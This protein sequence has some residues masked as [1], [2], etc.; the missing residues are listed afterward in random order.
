[1]RAPFTVLAL[2]AALALSSSAFALEISKYPRAYKGGEGLVVKVVSVKGEKKQALVQI[3]GVDTELDEIVLLTEEVNAGKGTALKTR[4]HGED[5]WVMR[6]DET[7]YG[8]KSMDVYLPETPTK[9]TNVYYDEAASKKVKGDALLK[10]YE[11]QKKDGTHAKLQKFNRADREKAQNKY[12]AEEVQS[13]ADACG[14]KIPATID[15]KAVSD[16]LLKDIS[17]H[18]Y[19]TPPLSALRSLC[20]KSPDLKAKVKA[21]VK[22]VACTFGATMKVTVAGGVVQWT[23]HKDSSNQDDFA[24]NNLQNALQ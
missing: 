13:T 2:L 4:L 16:D 15:W 8:W 12:Y 11:K 18:G 22:S 21:K 6:S 17:I 5:V 7:W 9:S 10:A 19:C 1:M 14:F 3:S 23:T 24:Q 20:G